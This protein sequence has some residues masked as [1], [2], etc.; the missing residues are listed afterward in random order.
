MSSERKE[1]ELDQL[2]KLGQLALMSAPEKETDALGRRIW[3]KVRAV[4]LETPTFSETPASAL[5]LPTRTKQHSTRAWAG[6]NENA[7]ACTRQRKRGVC[8]WLH[9]VLLREQSG[10]CESD[11]YENGLNQ[12]DCC[13]LLPV[14]AC[15]SLLPHSVRKQTIS[16]V[17]LLLGALAR[18]LL[19]LAH[20]PSSAPQS[21]PLATPASLPPF[22]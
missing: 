22:C 8:A 4:L 10:E 18:L 3:D 13:Y 7:C 1:T 17:V 11:S 15:S 9:A 6:G 2:Q 19:C 20:G 21:P 12:L 16:I 14:A 5:R